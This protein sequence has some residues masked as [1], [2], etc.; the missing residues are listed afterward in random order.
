MNKNT[1]LCQIQHSLRPF[2]YLLL[3]NSAGRIVR[4]L[5]W[6]D[7]EFFL[8]RHHFTNVLHAHNNLGMNNRPV[9]DRSS[10]T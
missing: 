3:D 5:W 10:E 2:L 7:H 9:D 1:S 6:T 8:C 4:D